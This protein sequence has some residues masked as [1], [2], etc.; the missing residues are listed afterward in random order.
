MYFGALPSTAVAQAAQCTA[1]GGVPTFRY[2]GYDANGMPLENTASYAG[3][4][5]PPAA[6]F[7]NSPPAQVTVTVPTQVQT[8]VSPQ[9]SPVFVQQSEPRD[10]AVNASTESLALQELLDTLKARDAA[11]PEYQYVAAP[12]PVSGE[13]P[14]PLPW[15]QSVPPV[16]WIVAA[17]LFG[18]ALI[19]GKKR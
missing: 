13:A 12:A 17:G 2:W 6:P 10:S 7:V 8:Q 18:V 5:Y 1:G 15:Y 9:V 14:A 19:A 16:A 3:C 11:P 4:N